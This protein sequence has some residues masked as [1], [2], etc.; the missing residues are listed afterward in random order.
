MPA[1]PDFEDGLLNQQNLLRLARTP[2]PY[3]KYQGRMLIDLPEEY[4]LWFA[5]KGFPE[6]QLGALLALCLELK[7]EGL[8]KLD[9]PLKQ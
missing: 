2:M 5:K 3:G 9:K 6:G 8:D 7:I 4:L 1:T